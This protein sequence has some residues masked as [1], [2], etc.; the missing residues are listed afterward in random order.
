MAAAV[1]AEQEQW[2]PLG[3]DMLEE[4]AAPELSGPSDPVFFTEAAVA[5][6]RRTEEL[7]E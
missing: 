1:E 7:L 5:R 2:A 3:V 4:L 6:E